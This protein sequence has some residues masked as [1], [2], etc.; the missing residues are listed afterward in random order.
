MDRSVVLGDYS[1]NDAHPIYTVPWAHANLS[2]PN[3]LIGSA[4]FAEDTR[5]H[6][7]YTYRP[8]YYMHTFGRTGVQDVLYTP[9]NK[10]NIASHG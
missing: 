4:V 8:R 10:A 3:I 5:P 1:P 2:L 9:A 6:E 7:Q